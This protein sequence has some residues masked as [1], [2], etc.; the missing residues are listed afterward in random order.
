MLAL[1]RD[2]T[3]AFEHKQNDGDSA[4]YREFDAAEDVAN[5]LSLVRPVTAEEALAQAV[6][7]YK[8]AAEIFHGIDDGTGS[9]EERKDLARQM[10]RRAFGLAQWIERMHQVDRRDFALS[11]YCCEASEG[12]IF[13]HAPAAAAKPDPAMV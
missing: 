10:L 3:L 4:D 12:M 7:L 13:P 5:M 6:F 11:G 1:F 2:L 8:D 9:D